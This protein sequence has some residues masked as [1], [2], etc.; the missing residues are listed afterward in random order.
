[1]DHISPCPIKSSFIKKIKKESKVHSESSKCEPTFGTSKPVEGNVP[2]FI[3]ESFVLVSFCKYWV[4]FFS[5]FFFAFLTAEIL[6]K[7]EQCFCFFLARNNVIGRE[8]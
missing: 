6:I 3:D 7:P 4:G 2:E 8:N 5:P 1:M